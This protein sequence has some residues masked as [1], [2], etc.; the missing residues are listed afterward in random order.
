QPTLS[1]STALT[2]VAPLSGLFRR[3]GMRQLRPLLAFPNTRSSSLTLPTLAKNTQGWGNHNGA[4]NT[5]ERG[6]AS[7]NKLIRSAGEVQGV[8]M[9]LPRGRQRVPLVRKQLEELIRGAS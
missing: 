7:N 5:T 3:M 8:K 9:G 2:M 6:P 4:W 1:R